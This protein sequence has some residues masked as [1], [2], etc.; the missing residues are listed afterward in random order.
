MTNEEAVVDEGHDQWETPT[1]FSTPSLTKLV[2][3]M[4]SS[5]YLNQRIPELA[6]AGGTGVS[7]EMARIIDYPT[8]TSLPEA[9]NILESKNNIKIMR[10]DLEKIRNYL[11]KSIGWSQWQGNSIINHKIVDGNYFYFVEGVDK[12][13]WDLTPKSDM[14]LITVWFNIGMTSITKM[15]R[16]QL[17]KCLNQS[18]QWEPPTFASL[19][20]VFLTHTLLLNTL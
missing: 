20:Q 17:E 15:G 12:R 10:A 19:S 6:S 1:I 14:D 18:P 11:K 3:F 8:K 4:K 16:D 2:P 13:F 5:N 7:N 9:S